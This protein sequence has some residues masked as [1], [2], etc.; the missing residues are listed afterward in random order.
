MISTPTEK[1]L[2]LNKSPNRPF[3][4]HADNKQ[5]GFK[6]RGVIMALIPIIPKILKIS[7]PTTFPTPISYFFLAIAA[8]VAASSGKE[9]QAATIVAHIAHSETQKYCAI[10]TAALTTKSE[11][12]TSTPRLAMS[13]VRVKSIHNLFSEECLSLL[14]NKET[15]NIIR[16]TE[17]KTIQ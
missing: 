1:I 12:R 3:S 8:I 17:R 16:R 14:K 13:L 2:S 4:H 5:L 6:L 7:D 15:K 11:E 10:N 9:V